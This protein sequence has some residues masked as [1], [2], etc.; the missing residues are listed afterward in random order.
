MARPAALEAPT[1]RRHEADR[2]PSSVGLAG[3]Q[4]GAI[5]RGEH[6][7]GLRIAQRAGPL[8]LGQ[9]LVDLGFITDEQLATLLEEQRHRPGELL[10]K[11]AMD[12]VMINDE[13]LAQALAEQMGLQTVVLS[14][15][16]IKP[17][18]LAIITE[19]MAQM[20]RVVPVDFED[21]RLTIAMCDP[22]NLAVQDELRS[23]L[24]FEIRVLVAPTPY[25]RDARENYAA[26]WRTKGT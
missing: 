26:S 16:R 2:G 17:D 20:Y 8:E 13:Q 11:I 1:R 18:V 3:E 10:G 19:P 25:S 12:L 22:Q 15:T 14:E 24:G 9:V 7:P 4:D 23:F 21:G 6:L 5:E